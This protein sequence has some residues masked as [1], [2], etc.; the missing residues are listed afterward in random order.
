MAARKAANDCVTTSLSELAL[1]ID[2]ASAGHYIPI[3]PATYCGTGGESRNLPCVPCWTAWVKTYPQFTQAIDIVNGRHPKQEKKT[4]SGEF[5]DFCQRCFTMFRLVKAGS[6]R[7]NGHCERC[8]P[9]ACE[10]CGGCGRP[11]FKPEDFNIPNHLHH[12]LKCTSCRPGCLYCGVV[13]TDENSCELARRDLSSTRGGIPAGHILTRDYD[14]SLASHARSGDLNPA[15]VTKVKPREPLHVFLHRSL[16]TEASPKWCQQILERVTSSL[17]ETPE[18]LVLLGPLGLT[19]PG[20]KVS[21][22]TM[23]RG[24][25]PREA[26][27]MVE[28]WRRLDNKM[29]DLIS[30]PPNGLHSRA[31]RSTVSNLSPAVRAPFIY[32][33]IDP[34]EGAPRSALIEGFVAQLERYDQPRDGAEMDA[35]AAE[36]RIRARQEAGDNTDPFLRHFL[37]PGREDR[38]QAQ[39][40]EVR[41]AANRVARLN[42]TGRWVMED[43]PTPP[44]PPP[45]AEWALHDPNPPANDADVGLGDDPRDHDTRDANTGV[46]QQRERGGDE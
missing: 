3:D 8:L 35:R 45:G 1:A 9:R 4:A 11:L 7:K 32:I 41:V 24:S 12:L 39:A 44:E 31:W 33:G 43:V 26:T 28:G 14:F 18:G 16:Y 6:K 25:L 30:Y 13:H 2:L 46:R 34:P 22:L 17:H 29:T 19:F 42:Q 36:L 38:P 40:H 21:W 5:I 20:K 27:A 15:R 37:Q 23:M 10:T